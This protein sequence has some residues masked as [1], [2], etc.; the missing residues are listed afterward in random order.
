MLADITPVV[1]VCTGPD[2]GNEPFGIGPSQAVKDQVYV[3]TGS[4]RV[5]RFAWGSVSDDDASTCDVDGDGAAAK[6]R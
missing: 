1:R 4:A 3:D 2:M 5:W 6:G